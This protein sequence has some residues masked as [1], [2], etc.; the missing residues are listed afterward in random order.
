LKPPRRSPIKKHKTAKAK[1]ASELK[2][3]IADQSLDELEGIEWGPPTYDS[4][5]VTNVHR[6]RSV[7]L[8]QYRLED[9]RLMISQ[10]FGIAYPVPLALDHLEVHALASGDFYHGN[11]TAAA[12]HRQL[13][14]RALHA[15]DEALA[16]IFKSVIGDCLRI[17][18]NGI[19]FLVCSNAFSIE[20]YWRETG[21][22]A[23]KPCGL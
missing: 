6:L 8:K 9:S 18:S 23:S 15:I 1:H 20:M 7:P 19:Q 10:Q 3:T 11:L 5:I 13:Q 4:S 14:P 22:H 21:P 12:I 17:V 2:R 16:R